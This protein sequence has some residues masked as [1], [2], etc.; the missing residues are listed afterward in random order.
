MLEGKT[1]AYLPVAMSFDLAQG[2]LAGLKQNSIRSASKSRS[3]IRIGAQTPGA[4]ALIDVITEKPDVIIVHN[5]DVQTYAKLL[6][7]AEVAGID[8]V[9]INMRSSYPT[10]PSAAPTGSRS[11]RR[12][13]SSGR[14]LQRQ[15]Q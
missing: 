13:R 3:A 10:T 14:F 12:T 11:A 7:K 6:Q 2:W 15:I 4:Q 1:V 5:P 9:Q 8:I